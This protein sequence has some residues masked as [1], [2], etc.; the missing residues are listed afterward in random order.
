MHRNPLTMY[1]RCLQTL[2]MR[3]RPSSLASLLKRVL[4]IRRTVIDTPHG[5]FW[6]DP[7]SNLGIALSRHGSYESGMQKTLE[8]FLPSGATFVDL[9]ANEGY[10]TVIGANEGGP[11]GRVVAI[12]PQ[13]RLIPVIAENLRLN[14]VEWASV[15]NV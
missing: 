11:R 9:G 4:G 5:R 2:L 10:F 3:V 7:I 8:K 15:L 6:V 1:Q 12:E 13:K 14:G